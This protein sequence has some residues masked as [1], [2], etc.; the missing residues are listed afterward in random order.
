MRDFLFIVTSDGDFTP[1][2]LVLLVH[3]AVQSAHYLRRASAAVHKVVEDLKDRKEGSSS[4]GESLRPRVTAFS[5]VFST[6]A[7]EADDEVE[8]ILENFCQ[9][10]REGPIR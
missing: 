2:E 10:Q 5:E 1:H 3:S 9:A 6:A 8:A 4:S 7:V